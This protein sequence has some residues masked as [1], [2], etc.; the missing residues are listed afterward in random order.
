[1]ALFILSDVWRQ[2]KKSW[3]QT[4]SLSVNQAAQHSFERKL[5]LIWAESFSAWQV[6]I[7]KIT[8]GAVLPFFFF[9]MKNAPKMMKIYRP[10]LTIL[11]NNFFCLGGTCKSYV[12][13]RFGYIFKSSINHSIIFNHVILS[14]KGGR[15]QT[16]NKTLVHQSTL[17]SSIF[18][19]MTDLT[20]K[21]LQWDWWQ[22]L[23]TLRK[24]KI[25]TIRRLYLN[26]NFEQF[27]YWMM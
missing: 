13:H 22:I 24:T 1:M 5:L 8:L 14:E 16:R 23:H 10:L 11:G 20:L 27:G 18:Y 17:N 3:T 6:A 4:Q 26:T 25:N 19:K 2:R 7:L 21:F 9:E 15:M 12:Q